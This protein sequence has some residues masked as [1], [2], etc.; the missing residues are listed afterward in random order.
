LSLQQAASLHAEL[1]SHVGHFSLHFA[2][3][4]LPGVIASICALAMSVT[5]TGTFIT[6]GSLALI[7]K[8]NWHFWVHS[9]HTG[10][11]CNTKLSVSLFLSMYIFS[12]HLFSVS[13]TFVIN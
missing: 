5:M 4:L 7:L 12:A 11:A 6:P 8:L 3:V 9:M 10:V 13:F 1:N 2:S